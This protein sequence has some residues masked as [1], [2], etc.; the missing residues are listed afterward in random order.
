MP[1]FLR[2]QVATC[3]FPGVGTDPAPMLFE[4][5]CIMYVFVFNV[6]PIAKV[7]RSRGYDVYSHTMDWRSLRSDLGPLDTRR[8]VYLLHVLNNMLSHD[9]Q[10]VI[11]NGKASVT[12][13]RAITESRD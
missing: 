11:C 8:M 4:L 10:T 13:D 9:R 3:D 7:V 12:R 5:F 1:V 2:K 6:P